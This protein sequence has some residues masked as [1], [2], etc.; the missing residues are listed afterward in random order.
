MPNVIAIDGPAASGKSSVSRNLAKVLGYTYVN[1][2]EFYRAITWQL[3]HDGVDLSS[4][5]KIGE[6]A[7]ALNIE[8][9]VQDRQVQCHI[10]GKHLDPFLREAFVNDNVSAVAKVP[11]VRDALT[12]IFRKL[13]ED[14]D[15]VVEGRDIGSVIFPDTPFKFYLDASPE[16]RR[17]RRSSQ[18][19]ADEIAARDRVDSTRKAAPLVISDDALVVDTTH[20]TLEGVVGEIYGRLKRMGLEVAA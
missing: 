4:P 15:V 14:V 20:L 8:T 7:A 6:A 12:P 18:G 5:E 1:S 19:Q 2:G 3:V 13:A 9:P 17:Q 11:A 10:G 16:V